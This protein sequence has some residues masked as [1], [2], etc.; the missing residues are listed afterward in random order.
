MLKTPDNTQLNLLSFQQISGPQMYAMLKLR[1]EVFVVEQHCIYQDM[2]DL[3]QQ[4]MHLIVTDSAGSI[5]AYARILP[6]G[7]AY[8]EAAIGRILTSE[9]WRGQ[10]YG[11][12]FIQQAVHCTQ[13]LYVDQHIRIGAQQHLQS[14]YQACGFVTVGEPYDEDGIMHVQMLLE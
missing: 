4:A 12:W 1:S 3:D 2:D 7:T 5:D 10:G 11:R 13:Q 14:L 8:T 6:P 9:A